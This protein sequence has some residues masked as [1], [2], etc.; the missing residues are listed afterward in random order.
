MGKNAAPVRGEITP[1]GA[2]MGLTVSDVMKLPSMVGAQVLAGHAGL[3]NPVE[4][5]SVLE[6]GAATETLDQLF[7][8]NT[9]AGNEL[10]IT[11]FA[12]IQDDVDAQCDNIRRYHAVGSVG[13]VIYYVGIIL[14]EIDQRLIDVCDELG[15]VLISMPPGKINLRY[16]ELLTEV[17]FSIFREQQRNRFF[18]STILDRLSGLPAEQRNMN[19]L[20]HMLSEHLR[21]SAILTDRKGKLDTAVFWPWIIAERVSGDVPAWI[22]KMGASSRLSVPMED[23]TG[24]LY[25]CPTLLNDSDDLQLYLLKFD[26]QLTDD[27]LWQSSELIRLFIHIWNKNHGKFVTAELVR[28]I[29]NGNQLQMNQLAEVFHIQVKDLN[30]MWIFLPL[31]EGRGYDEKLLQRCTD[32]LS[33]SSSAFIISYYEE[34]LI[35]F[36]HGAAAAA[37]RENIE[38]DLVQ[39]LADLE[40]PYEIVCCNCLDTIEAVRSAYLEST[41]HFDIARK[42]HP[43]K[44]ILHMSDI[45]FAMT[46]KQIIDTPS[47]LEQFLPILEQLKKATPELISTLSAYLLDADSNMAKTAKLQFVHLNTIKYRL[48]S[49]QDLLGFAPSQMPDAYP[50]YVAAALMRIL[51]K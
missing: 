49:A 32:C 15:F 17:L 23:T 8:D 5:I 43:A 33:H 1:G 18:V 47:A 26:E 4:S 24:W 31:S 45:L 25:R 36:A 6:Y 29:I 38:Q 9:F 20:L 34:N 48:R 37:Q 46:C 7:R 42:I 14:P 28:A 39:C 51:D 13:V 19:T 10:V 27:I 44:K 41:R 22:K 30:Q 21:V 50:L 35:A 12:N 11:A 40:A 3:S 2:R 16:S